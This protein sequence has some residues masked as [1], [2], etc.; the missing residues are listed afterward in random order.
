MAGLGE[1]FP[2]AVQIDLPSLVWLL[3]STALVLLMTPGLAFFY[4]GLVRKKKHAQHHDD[5]FR[6]ARRCWY[7]LGLP[8]PGAVISFLGSP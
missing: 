4:G 5:V 6:I 3:L 1:S 2:S 7:R 8:R